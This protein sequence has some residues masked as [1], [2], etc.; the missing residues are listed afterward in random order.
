MLRALLALSA[1]CLLLSCTANV[2]TSPADQRAKIIP[3]T[4]EFT[5]AAEAFYQKR[6]DLS[7]E[8]FKSGRGTT[9]Y[10][11]EIYFGQN[12]KP[13]PLPRGK[14]IIPQSALTELT[15]YAEQ[16]NS[17]SFMIY[18]EGKIIAETYFGQTDAQS[19][20][21]AKSL[22]KPIGVIAVGRAIK[23]GYIEGLDQPISDFIPE[24]V[25]TQKADIK[26]RYLLDMRSGLLPQ[27]R[28]TGADDVLNRAYLHPHHDEV[29]IHEYPLTHE[30]GSRYEYSNVNSELVAVLIS[31]ATGQSYEDWLTHEVLAPLGA[32]GGKIWLNREGGLA[33]SG[34]CVGLT[35]ET[36]LKLAVM[37]SQKGQWDGEAFLPQDFIAEMTT[38]TPQNKYAAMGV[39]VGRDY[40]ERRGAANPD[41]ERDFSASLHS[42]PY[43]DKDILLFDGNGNQVVY[44]LP[45][46][47]I[48]ILRLGPRPKHS[49]PWDTSF[50]PNH[51]VR[52]IAK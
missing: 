7:V 41:I 35:S 10:D 45:S 12:L 36:Y 21:N 20:I 38:P 46:R 14:S 25:G 26:I 27:G 42:E 40:K 50:L 13:R 17:D 49:E 52:A 11:T 19:L 48:V 32:A 31:R 29:I 44:M 28:P 30:P 24:W 8:A 5:E 33:H 1:G 15:A 34:C 47:N 16:H 43:L 39:Y 6:Y 37:I 2:N 18:H 23:A 51:L 22:A 9:D 4:G 3:T